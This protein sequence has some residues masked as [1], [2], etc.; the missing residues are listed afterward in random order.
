[1]WSGLLWG[2]GR[3]PCD[4]SD[5]S[6]WLDNSRACVWSHEIIRAISFK[7]C[8]PS[9]TH[10]ATTRKMAILVLKES[11]DKYTS[12]SY[13]CSMLDECV[14]AYLKQEWGLTKFIWVKVQKK[15]KKSHQWCYI[16]PAPLNTPYVCTAT[17]D[18]EHHDNKVR[19][20]WFHWGINN[21]PTGP[22]LMLRSTN[23]SRGLIHD[24][25]VD[26]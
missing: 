6:E 26:S 9:T 23:G 20:P 5:K 22:C 16:P 18:T 8:P 4:W 7:E 1:M 11:N 15:K 12:P 17:P 10:G 13:T 14:T 19:Q 2:L 25:T 3:L 24:R 21:R